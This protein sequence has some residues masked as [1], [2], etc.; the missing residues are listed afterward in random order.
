[1]KQSST[2]EIEDQ[3]LAR[4]KRQ[5]EEL[6]ECIARKRAIMA[7]E[8]KTKTLGN[9]SEFKK[10]YDFASCSDD[11]DITVTNK[12]PWQLDLKPDLQPK[13][14]I[15]KNRSES[16]TDQPQVCLIL[17]MLICVEYG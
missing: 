16:V 13:K 8:H 6:S 5:L 1:M 14:S 17:L 2:L 7:M 3:E 4:K 10:K 11:L 12:N 15:L 9:E